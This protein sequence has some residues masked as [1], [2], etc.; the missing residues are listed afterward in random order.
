MNIC[1]VVYKVN[2]VKELKLF[3]SFATSRKK[4]W[5]DIML[6]ITY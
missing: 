1:G 2:L 6:L 5:F 4:Q 3:L